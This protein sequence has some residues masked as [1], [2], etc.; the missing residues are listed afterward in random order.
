[1]T[2]LSKHIR[3][4]HQV[5]HTHL[6]EAFQAKL[7]GM[8]SNTPAPDT[9]MLQQV[10]PLVAESLEDIRVDSSNVHRQLLLVNNTLSDVKDA[11]SKDSHMTPAT[12]RREVSDALVVA[13]RSICS[14][15][16]PPRTEDP[17]LADE[18]T[19]GPSSRAEMCTQEVTQ[20]VT[21]PISFRMSRQIHTVRQA[22]TEYKYGYPSNPSVQAI[23]AERGAQWGRKNGD[24][25]FYLRRKPLYQA[26]EEAIL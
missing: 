20:E 8:V 12:L 15:T 5:F 14:V 18:P 17:F 25:Q 6:F 26:I 2:R 24:T 21:T 16:V 13:A 10:M 9:V 11:F 1:M 19:S 4:F 3:F 7:Q 22:W 23:E